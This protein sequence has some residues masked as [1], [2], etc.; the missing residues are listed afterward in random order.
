M[1]TLA[2]RERI[3]LDCAI[4]YVY[5]NLHCRFLNVRHRLPITSFAQLCTT[6]KHMS[7]VSTLHRSIARTT[8]SQLLKSSTYLSSFRLS[9]SSSQVRFSNTVSTMSL[10]SPVPIALCGKSQT[11][12]TNFSDSMSKEGYEGLSF[13]SLIKQSNPMHN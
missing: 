1:T 6:N 10:P 7:L 12:A 3:P 5:K 8:L 11:M 9:K 13:T 4:V 2:C